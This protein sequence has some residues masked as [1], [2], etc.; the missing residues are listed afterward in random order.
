MSQRSSS[1]LL[2]FWNNIGVLFNCV[3][4]IKPATPWNL[5]TLVRN[6]DVRLKL[7]LSKKK[8][9]YKMLQFRRLVFTPRAR[10]FFGLALIVLGYLLYVFSSV[11]IRC[12]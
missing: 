2:N 3:P 6:C 1:L 7:Y 8:K 9:T 11:N 12:Q 5:I 4:G 10:C